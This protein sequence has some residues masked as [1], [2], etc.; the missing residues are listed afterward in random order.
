MRNL[1]ALS[2]LFFCFGFM[3]RAQVPTPMSTNSSSGVTVPDTTEKN[4]IKDCEY[5]D[6]INGWGKKLFSYGYYE[7]FWSNGK[8]NGYGMFDWS[9]SGKYIGFWVSDKMT[10]YGVYIGVEQ[11]M[12]GEYTDGMIQ[13][14]GYIVKGDDWKQGVY[15]LS[16]LVESYPFVSNDVNSGCTAGDCQ[17]KYGRYKWSNGDSFTGF[18]K[19]G[20]MY[21][22][23]YL[24]ASGD[25]Y[26]GMFNNNN[27]FHGQGRFFFSN[28]DYYGGE[29]LNGKYHG[30]GYFQGQTAA[31]DK[32]GEWSNGT[33][34][35]RL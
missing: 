2:V 12:V 6:C 27:Q 34:I 13:G 21:M 4:T 14:L 23:T 24:F 20:K 15:N 18:F 32:I 1:V 28:K 16:Q 35:K 17:N 9:D 33:F 25:K 11:D 26:T 7:G 5:G 3:G 10:G 19:N 8:R 31:D 29:W 22:G 30:R